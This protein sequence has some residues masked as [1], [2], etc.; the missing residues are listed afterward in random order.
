[1]SEQM[2]KQSRPQNTVESAEIFALHAEFCKVIANPT[3]LMLISRL[4]SGELTVGEL[5]KG[6]GASLANI[7]QHL[8]ILRDHDIVRTR[9]E[10]RS[11]Y[12][13][14]R[15]ARLVQVCELTRAILLGGIRQRGA[16]ARSAPGKRA[17]T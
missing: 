5:V 9:R 4:R 12:Y 7:S 2:L 6:T 10:G 13:R 1:M 8:R 3:R 15:D 14:L 11:I 16:L 17:S